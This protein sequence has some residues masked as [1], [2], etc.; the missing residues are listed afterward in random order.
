MVRHRRNDDLALRYFRPVSRACHIDAPWV[1][2]TAGHGTLKDAMNEAL[3]DWVT[4]VEDTYY[5]I[6][7][8]AGP[9]PYPEIVRDL[10]SVIGREA[11]EQILAAEGKL[12]DLLV[13]AVGVKDLIVVDTPDA[14]L[15]CPR[16]RAQDVKRLVDTLKE[17]GAVDLL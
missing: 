3:R 16:E 6:G 14:L 2:V 5:M 12:P 1:P 11:R 9:H 4:N 17:R 8:A 15:I 13:A 10:Q 7:T